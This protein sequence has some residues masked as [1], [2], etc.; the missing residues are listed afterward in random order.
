MRYGLSPSK[1]TKIF[2]MKYTLFI[3]ALI[4][5]IAGHSLAVEANTD[6]AFTDQEK[7]FL[8]N[9]SRQ[10]VSWQLKY[11]T[12]PEPDKRKISR[13]LMRHLGCFVTLTHKEKGLRGCIGI[14]ERREPLYKNVISRAIAATHDRRFRRNPVTHEE[15]KDIKIEIS[16]LTEPRHLYF[17]SPEGLLCKLRPKVDGVILYTQYG[18]STYLPQV[19]EQIPGKEDFLSYLCRNHGAPMDTWKK[20]FRNVR[21]QTYQTI[22]F[23]EESYGRKV[24]GPKGALV[25]K[26][27]DRVVG[28]V[29]LL[30]KRLA[31]GGGPLVEGTRL[32]P[33]TIVTWASDIIEP[34]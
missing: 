18:S 11:D 9:L 19:W 12:T 27:G 5:F 21:I 16:V 8:L 25:G 7:S 28:E 4:A 23:Y 29:K 14:F 30:G 2:K 15:L 1:T 20:D 26:M 33:G 10:T 22:V 13:I 31:S 24:V 32:A 17:N 6:S 3:L 34:K